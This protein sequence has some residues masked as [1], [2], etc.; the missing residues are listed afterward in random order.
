MDDSTA[1]LTRSIESRTIRAPKGSPPVDGPPRHTPALG[2]GGFPEKPPPLS[3]VTPNLIPMVHPWPLDDGGAVAETGPGHSDVE[4]PS[5]LI[6]QRET[7]AAQRP[8]LP[9]LIIVAVAVQR[10][11]HPPAVGRERAQAAGADTQEAALRPGQ[12]STD[13]SAATG[14]YVGVGLPGRRHNESRTVAWA[15][16]WA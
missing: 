15:Q 11:A 10:Q 4:V 6:F 2:G 9:E 1:R 7:T 12:A 13:E 16:C 14:S 5:S 3:P 8:R